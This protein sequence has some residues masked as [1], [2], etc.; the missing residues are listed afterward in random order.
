MGKNE[1]IIEVQ[2]RT[3]DNGKSTRSLE[4]H[5]LDSSKEKTFASRDTLD[6]MQVQELNPRE[7][8]TFQ[9]PANTQHRVMMEMITGLQVCNA[10][11]HPSQQFDDP[12][13]GELDPDIWRV[14]EAGAS[15]PQQGVTSLE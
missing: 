5:V 9:E 4:P 8:I 13:S 7:T 3:G 12:R 6:G 1:Q 15:F 11:P 14:Y 2:A 10:R